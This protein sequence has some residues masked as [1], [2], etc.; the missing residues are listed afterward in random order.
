MN[1]PEFRDVGKRLKNL[2]GILEEERVVRDLL[3]AGED[4]G[5]R[6]TIG[7]E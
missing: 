2:L 4:S 6:I 1:Q 7:S 3:V 5:L